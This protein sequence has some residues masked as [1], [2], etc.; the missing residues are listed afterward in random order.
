M[1]PSCG[2][3]GPAEDTEDA[4]IAAWNRLSYRKPT[5]VVI[6]AYRHIATGGVVYAIEELD[7]IDPKGWKFLDCRSVE[8]DVE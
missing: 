6:H 3:S 1:H 7:K 8:F 4:A 2:L 5:E